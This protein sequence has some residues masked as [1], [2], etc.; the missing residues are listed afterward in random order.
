MYEWRGGSW[1]A[2]KWAD[3]IP[4]LQEIT[5]LGI[6]I[7]PIAETSENRKEFVFYQ[8]IIKE[9]GWGNKFYRTKGNLYY[10]DVVKQIVLKVIE[11]I[12]E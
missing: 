1:C 8:G 9:P 2:G 3:T 7:Y 5:G 12:E 6:G 11:L 4:Y 10:L